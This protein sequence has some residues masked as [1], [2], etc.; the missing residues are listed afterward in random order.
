[1]MHCF[2]CDR[3]FDPKEQDHARYEYPLPIMCQ[4]CVDEENER[5]KQIEIE[6]SWVADHF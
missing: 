2:Y 1:M 4:D 5:F 3:D 6:E